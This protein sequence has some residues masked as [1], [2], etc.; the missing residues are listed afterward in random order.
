MTGGCPAG[1]ARASVHCV[2]ALVLVAVS[3]GLSNFAAAIAIGTA[4][5][6]AR[7]RLRVG[8]VFGLFEAGMPLIGLLIGD[9]FASQ[10]GHAG[11]WIGAAMLISV[12][13]YGLINSFRRARVPD[14]RTGRTTGGW[15]LLLGGLALSIDNLVVGFALG[16][17]QVPILTGVAV[18]GAISVGLSLLGLELGARLGKWAGRR[19]EQ[20]G[21]LILISVG[22]VIG[23]GRLN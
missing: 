22:L 23:S 8:L 1:P 19:S 4:G 5:V 12:G 7:T 9:R 20:L 6:D 21:S 15:R 3:V 17:Y 14:P 2:L 13:I 10:L 18:I 11:R 16:T